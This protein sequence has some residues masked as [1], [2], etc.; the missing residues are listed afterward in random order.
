MDIKEAKWQHG[1]G[2]WFTNTR[3]Q[4]HLQV[5]QKLGYKYLTDKA[6]EAKLTT[7]LQREHW[8]GSH[9]TASLP[10]S[11]RGLCTPLQKWKRQCSISVRTT[12]S[13]WIQD[14]LRLITGPNVSEPWFLI[15]KMRIVIVPTTVDCCKNKRGKAC[16]PAGLVK[17]RK[18]RQ[19]SAYRYV[20][21]YV[22]PKP[23]Q[24]TFVPF[25]RCEEIITIPRSH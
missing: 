13:E 3:P 15:C 16:T 10:F 22:Q 7:W 17:P 19:F 20:V 5:H 25:A 9:E 18:E 4:A 12:G 8:T 1:L 21:L 11:W 6:L 2:T 24:G 23:A 14:S